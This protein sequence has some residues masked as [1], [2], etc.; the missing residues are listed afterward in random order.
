MIALFSN[1]KEKK[2]ESSVNRAPGRGRVYKSITETIGDTPIVELEKIAREP[3]PIC[4][5]HDR[6]LAV[7]PEM[8]QGIIRDR[9]IR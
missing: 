5:T 2:V 9:P 3:G 1:R 7:I 6:C 8:P 4:G